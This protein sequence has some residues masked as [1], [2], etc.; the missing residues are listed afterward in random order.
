MQQLALKVL[1]ERKPRL[2]TVDGKGEGLLACGGEKTVF[3]DLISGGPQLVIIGNGH[4]G[5]AVAKIADGC[6]WQVSV[7]D[8]RPLLEDSC[9]EFLQISDYAAPFSGL[10]PGEQSFVLIA[11]RSHDTDLQA[12]RAAL[13]T[14]AAFIGL[15]GSSRKKA[16]FF[17]ALREEGMTEEQLRRVASP[18]GLE[19]G[20]SSPAEIAVS[21]MAQMIQIKESW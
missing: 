3:L 1:A 19:I 7:R 17:A 15:L 4:V 6:G 10:V 9:G 20:A 12:L 8:D 16:A 13:D 11:S 14:S 18:V 5:Q 21:I 2:V